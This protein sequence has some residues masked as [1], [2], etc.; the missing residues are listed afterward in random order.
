MNTDIL[1][2]I[3][4]LAGFYNVLVCYQ[5]NIGAYFF[6]NYQFKK[7]HLRMHFFNSIHDLF[8][9]ARQIYHI[10]MIILNKSILSFFISFDI[11]IKC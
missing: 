1:I 9:T 4:Y 5:K 7:L 11:T 2:D 10:I 8:M 6:Q 3:M